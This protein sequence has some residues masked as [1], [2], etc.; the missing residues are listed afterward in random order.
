VAT[1]EIHMV[2]SMGIYF[3]EIT[4]VLC[5]GVDGNAL[6]AVVTIPELNNSQLT[7]HILVDVCQ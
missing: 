1:Y 7:C 3:H 5:M 2:A 6:E 4:M